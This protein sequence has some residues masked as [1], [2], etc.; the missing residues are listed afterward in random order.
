M[1]NT[2]PHC[3][4]S[5]SLRYDFSMYF[6]RPHYKAKSTVKNK[7][8]SVFK[9]NTKPKIKKKFVLVAGHGYNN[10]GAKGDGT[11]ERDFIR[12]NIIDDVAKYLRRAGQWIDFISVTKKDGYWWVRFKYPTNPGAG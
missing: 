12:K 4:S 2:H 8:T 5:F 7:V 10:P 3:P 11:N 1:V 6:I 9:P